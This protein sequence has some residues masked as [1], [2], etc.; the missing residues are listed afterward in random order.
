M[1]P[2]KQAARLVSAPSVTQAAPGPALA[3][4]PELLAGL[5]S[6]LN[7]LEEAGLPVKLAH[8]AALT[9]A[10]FVFRLLPPHEPGPAGATW[11]PR[12]RMLTEFPV[13]DGGDFDD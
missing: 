13:P 9:D 5:A 12:S 6:A 2:G 7:A 11:Q 1:K 8:G 4:A 10:G 3:R